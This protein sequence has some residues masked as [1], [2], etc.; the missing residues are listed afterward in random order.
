MRHHV[1]FELGLVLA[2]RSPA[3]LQPSLNPLLL[4]LPADMSVDARLVGT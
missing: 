2:L 4:L 3:C 1:T